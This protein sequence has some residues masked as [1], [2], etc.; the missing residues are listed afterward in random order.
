MRRLI[1]LALLL[2]AGLIL[3]SLVTILV[4]AQNSGG[5]LVVTTC[6]TA[7]PTYVAGAMMPITQNTSGQVCQ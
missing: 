2:L 5:A 7:P 6:G 3:S 1:G 4:R